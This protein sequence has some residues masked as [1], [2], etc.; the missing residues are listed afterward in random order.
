MMVPILCQPQVLWAAG[1]AP[2]AGRVLEPGLRLGWCIWL[3]EELQEDFVA[4]VPAQAM[5]FGAGALFPT[6]PAP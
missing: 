2:E 1:G 4:A 3:R 5:G 6:L